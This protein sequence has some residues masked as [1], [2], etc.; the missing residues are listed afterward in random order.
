ML[1]ML[2]FILLSVKWQQWFNAARPNVSV[3]QIH[4]LLI[5]ENKTLI[6][7][8]SKINVIHIPCL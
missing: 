1:L 2:L 7:I 8:H 3:T 5:L 6:N 4:N